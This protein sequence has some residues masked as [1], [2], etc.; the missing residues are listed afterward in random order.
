M[1]ETLK[2]N[3]ITNMDATPAI[4]PTSGEGAGGR[5]IVQTDDTSPTLSAAIWST[6][7]MSRFPTNAKVKH[8]WT[9]QTGLESAATTGALIY[10]YNICF[11]DDTND[12]TP[13]ALQALIPSNKNDGT[14]FEMRTT[15]YSTSY[16]ST[17][18]ANKL[19]GASI[20]QVNSTAQNLELTY[21]NTFTPANRIDDLWNVLGFTST[22]VGPTDP[23]GFFDIFVVVAAAASA[24]ALGKIGVEVDYV[25]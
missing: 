17:G 16:A 20:A 2:S 1:A 22:S 21:K 12:G 24:A 13:Q 19:F 18:T 9:Y 6:Y 25:V 15:G 10:D 5:Q 11:S 3:A 23:G 7:R 8:V 14:A 4:M